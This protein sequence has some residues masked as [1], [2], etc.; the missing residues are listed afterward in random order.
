LFE[1]LGRRG[2]PTLAER[3]DQLGHLLLVRLLD[4]VDGR[5][6]AIREP[7]E[8]HRML[9][10]GAAEGGRFVVVPGLE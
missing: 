9:E 1:G 5:F 2:G 7:D 6:T 8:R 10:H 4:G 3:L